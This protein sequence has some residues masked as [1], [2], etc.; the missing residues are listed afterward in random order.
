[1]R[2]YGTGGRIKTRIAD[3][4][5]PGAAIVVGYV[6]E[7]PLNGIIRVGAFVHRH[8]RLARGCSAFFAGGLGFGAAFHGAV[9]NGGRHICP[10]AF[11]HPPTPNILIHKNILIVHQRSRRAETARI[12]IGTVGGHA[13]AGAL[14]QKRVFVG[15]RSIFGHIDVGVQLGAVAHR[16]VGLDFGVVVADKCVFWC[17]SLLA[18]RGQT[19]SQRRQG[20]EPFLHRTK[21]LMM[22]PKGSELWGNWGGKGWGIGDGGGLISKV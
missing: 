14:H 16:D 7:Q 6:F 5:L 15:R 12:G 19:N 20:K 18:I 2:P 21:R 13:V 1:M 10:R 11:R 22:K 17:G 4:P 3:A 9:G 8:C